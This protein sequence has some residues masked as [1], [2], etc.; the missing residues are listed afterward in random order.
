MNRIQAF[1]LMTLLAATAS[2]APQVDAAAIKA[3]ATRAL[4]RCADQTIALDRVDTPAPTGFVEFALTQ[5]S[6]DST[7]GKKTMLL[8]S[9]ST[10]QIL[11]GSVISLPIDNRSLEA[12]VADAVSERLRVPINAKMSRGFPLPDALKP[13][14]MTKATDQ[15][16]F[17]Y[18]GYVDASEQ[19]LI[20]ASRGNLKT[21]PGS[22]LIDALGITSAM[23]RGNAKSK[24][25]IIEISDFECP[26]CGRAHKVVEPIIEKNLSKIDYYRLD[27]PLF[28]MHKWALDAASGARAISKVAPKLYWD[29][30][31][32]VFANQDAFDKMPLEPALKDWVEAHN[33]SWPAIEKI[34]KSPVERAALVDQVSRF[35]DLGIN[36]TPTYII[37][38]QIMGYGPDG[39]FTIDAVKKAIGAK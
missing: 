37:N 23:R 26:T 21:D 16:P 11:M 20:V 31:N 14:L 10:Q 25:K 15:G 35:V 4:P 32:Y 22:T 33:V 24:V 36:S 38:G 27:L 34:Y 2:A 5:T 9:P 18:R 29:Y 8:Y 1:L 28:E 13:V 19:F 17:D 30:V 39:K 6:S 7:C 3:Y 12:R